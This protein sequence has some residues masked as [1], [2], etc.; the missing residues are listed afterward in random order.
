MFLTNCMIV[1]MNNHVL[2]LKMIVFRYYYWIIQIVC[3][4]KYTRSLFT[5]HKRLLMEVW[6]V[7]LLQSVSCS[8]A[9]YRKNS[10]KTTLG[11]CLALTEWSKNARCWGTVPGKVKPVPS[12]PS[13]VS[14]TRSMPSKLCII[15]RQW[16]WV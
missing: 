5:L 12:L 11:T 15:P 8:L 1:W 13:L 7:L 4:T 2:I 3:Y 9:C 16:R 14:S 6:Y 10:R